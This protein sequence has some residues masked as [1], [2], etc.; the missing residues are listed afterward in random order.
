VAG[1]FLNKFNLEPDT[2][3]TEEKAQ[4]V[5]RYKL[6]DWSD[7]DPAYEGVYLN[8][9]P[10]TDLIVIDV[11]YDGISDPIFEQ[12]LV[13]CED[14]DPEVRRDFIC[15]RSGKRSAII[16]VVQQDGKEEFY[17]LKGCG[18]LTLGFNL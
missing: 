14:Q 12:V 4:S 11:R 7:L 17:R 16:N 2:Q 9:I 6:R 1:Q 3:V 10:S 8:A 15:Y 5:L 13:K 18:N